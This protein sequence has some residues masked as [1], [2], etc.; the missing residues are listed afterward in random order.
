MAWIKQQYHTRYDSVSIIICH[1]MTPK[2]FKHTVHYG[3][4]HN[5]SIL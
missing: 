2:F 5:N 3:M 4:D 1:L